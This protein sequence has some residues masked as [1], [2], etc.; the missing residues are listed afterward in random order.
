MP[1]LVAQGMH[2][3]HRWRRVLKEDA[4]FVIGREGGPWA[5]PWDDRISRRHAAAIWDGRRLRVERLPTAAN[6]IFFRGAPSDRFLVRPGEHFV[7]G[8]ATFT[9]TEQQAEITLEAPSPRCEETLSPEFLHDAPFRDTE[10]RIDIL[11]RLPEIIQSASNDE[12]LCAKL[13]TALL[14]GIPRATA[15]AIIAQTSDEPFEVLHWDRRTLTHD[16]FHPSRQLLERALESR[17]CVLHVWSPAA[18]KSTAES[19]TGFT[20]RPDVDW[21][22]CTLAPQ[23]N[24]QQWLVYIA[25]RAEEH[26]SD[27]HGQTPLALN[28]DNLRDEFKF[29]QLVASTVGALRS[30]QR[31]ERRNASLGQF[32][33]PLVLDALRDQDPEQVLA[34]RET[35]ITTLFCDL[36]GFS[37]HS[38]ESADDLLGLLE[39][40]SRALGVMTHA[41]HEHGGVV[42]DFHGDAAMGFWGWPFE[43]ADGIE[44]ACRA[45]LDIRSHFAAAAAQSEHPLHAFRMGIGIASGRAVAG[46]MGAADQVK[47]TVFGPVVNLASRLEGLTKLLRAPIL[48]DEPT[49]EKIRRV[50]L[51]GVRVRRLA[52]I[53]PPGMTTSLEVSELLP[54]EAELPSLRDEH[55]AAYEQA[56]QAF[57]AGDWNL[58]YERLHQVPAADFAKD[59]LLVQIARRNRA[60]PANWDGVIRFDA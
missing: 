18:E 4:A 29:V 7:I 37:R 5:T 51:D 2:P 42:G 10:Q 26:G 16:D 47:V 34:P 58:A 59:F 53:Q 14:R 56:L 57:L 43:Q 60:A 28:A 21:A 32:F 13:I 25:G 46:K 36:R 9:V 23:N 35:D 27:A 15:A 44:R 24:N 40:V 22:I 33:S 11:S 39:R 20:Q 54:S 3:H 48:L 6:P 41:I 31:L 1:D 50:S 38:E 49:A 45:A 19:Q 52:V 55:L 8:G 30:L 17:E 12:D